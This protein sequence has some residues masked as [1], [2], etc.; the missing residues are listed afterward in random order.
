MHCAHNWLLAAPACPPHTQ[1]PAP[2]PATPALAART[3][4]ARSTGSWPRRRGRRATAS[5]S[6]SVSAGLLSA[7]SLVLCQLLM[8]CGRVARLSL[9]QQQC[10]ASNQEA[11]LVWTCRVTPRAL[12]TLQRWTQARSRGPTASCGTHCLFLLKSPCLP[13]I[14]QRWTLERSR[15]RTASCGSL[16]RRRSC[17]SLS[18]WVAPCCHWAKGCHARVVGCHSRAVGCH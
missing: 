17:C 18:T 1:L 13:S 15:G 8:A 14:L 3:H 12:S 6:S 2:L 7:G 11:G 16:R 10:G 4:A 9:H 5:P